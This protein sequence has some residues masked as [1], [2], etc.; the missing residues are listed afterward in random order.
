MATAIDSG[1]GQVNEGNLWITRPGY[2]PPGAGPGIR[3]QDGFGVVTGNWACVLANGVQPSAS[4][5]TL[6]GTF[7]VDLLTGTLDCVNFP[8]N[9][10]PGGG[11]NW[12]QAMKWKVGGNRA[13]VN[14]GTDGRGTIGPNLN[15]V[16]APTPGRGDRNYT[17]NPGTGVSTDSATTVLD[18]TGAAADYNAVPHRWQAAE[19]GFAGT[20][21]VG[22]FAWASSYYR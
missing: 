6:D 18:S 11:Q 20:P 22:S 9:E 13:I 16:A 19:N 8:Q 12:P 3:C 2:T 4:G 21:E 7:S 14:I 5:F 15:R 10:T 17:V 1:R